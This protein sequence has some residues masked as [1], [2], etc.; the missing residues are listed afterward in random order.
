MPSAART[1][2]NSLASKPLE[3]G[4]TRWPFSFTESKTDKS[5]SIGK[6]RTSRRSCS[7]FRANRGGGSYSGCCL[8]ALPCLPGASRC[9]ELKNDQKSRILRDHK[10]ITTQV[11]ITWRIQDDS[12]SL[13]RTVRSS[14]TLRQPVCSVGLPQHSTTLWIAPARRRLLGSSQVCAAWIERR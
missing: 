8:T 9:D 4:S 11:T 14:P 5:R 13:C 10:G 7:S 2:A 6:S 1:K 3:E 12:L